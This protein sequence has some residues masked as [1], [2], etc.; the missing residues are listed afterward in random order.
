M[1][2]IVH[3]EDSAPESVQPV[4]AKVKGKFGFVPNILGVMADSPALLKAYLTLAELFESTSLTATEKQIVLLT[5]SF[6]NKCS[7]CMAVHTILAEKQNVDAGVVEAIRKNTVMNDQ[8]LEALRVFVKEVVDMRGYPSEV[9]L[10]RFLAAGYTKTQALEV[11]LGVGQKT[12]SNYTSHL[13]NTQLDEAFSP[14]VWH[15]DNEL[16][17]GCKTHCCG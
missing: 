14:A 16:E 4:L 15:E 7:Y 13:T 1:T 17:S 6:V 10:G 2:F 3:N 12:L 5:T 9:A 11:M 8:K